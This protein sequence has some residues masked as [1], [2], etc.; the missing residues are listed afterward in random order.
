[1]T[2]DGALKLGWFFKA[3]L[4][5]GKGARSSMD[6]PLDTGYSKKGDVSLGEGFS[7]VKGNSQGGLT[8]PATLPTTKKMTSFSPQLGIWELSKS[9]KF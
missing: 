6:Y 5:W 7:S 1:M 3:V 9:D 8:A 2:P 4:C